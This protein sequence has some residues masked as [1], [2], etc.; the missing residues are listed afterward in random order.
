MESALMGHQ[1]DLFT[2]LENPRKP[3]RLRGRCE[4]HTLELCMMKYGDLS[5]IVWR[6][7]H[8]VP[9][10]GSR[11]V[12]LVEAKGAK[13]VPY[14]RYAEPTSDYTVEW[15]FYSH[16]EQLWAYRVVDVD[17]D[18]A[19][20]MR[21]AANHDNGVTNWDVVAPILRRLH[22]RGIGLELTQLRDWEYMPIVTAERW[23]DHTEIF[24]G[25]LL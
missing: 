9:L 13:K 6:V 11:R 17:D 19:D 20:I 12:Q 25:S 8:D 10:A 15:G 18:T 4:S 22:N 21:I 23:D 16:G 3:T 24:Q 7:G 2:V 1:E 5:G 14:R